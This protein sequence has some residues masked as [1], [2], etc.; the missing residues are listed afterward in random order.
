VDQIKENEVGRAYGT[1]VRG[2]EHVQ[3]FGGKA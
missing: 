1:H 2:K 3:H